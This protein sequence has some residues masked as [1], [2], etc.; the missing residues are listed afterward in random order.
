MAIK[1]YWGSGSPFAW[2]V[3]LTLEIKGLAYESKLLEFSKGEHKA[4]DYLRL[5]PRGKVP[6]LQDDDFVLYESHAI[7][8]YLDRRYPEPPIFG[9]TPQETGLIW[10]SISE[11]ESYLTAA[12]NNLVRPIF[13]GKGLD[14]TEELQQAA[15]TIRQEFKTLDQ[16]LTHSRWLV[17]DQLSAA[18]ISVFPLTQLILRAANKEAAQPLNLTLLPFDQTYPHVGSW[19]QR[20]EAL[21]RYERTYPPHWRA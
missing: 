18:D 1:L 13:F 14:K 8:M 19:I 7:M 21:P 6:T 20:I 9:S 2:R 17:G 10:Q 11:T 12:A 3:M 16:R 4:P 5:N 15:E